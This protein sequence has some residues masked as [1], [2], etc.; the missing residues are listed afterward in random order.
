MWGGIVAFIFVNPLIMCQQ[1]QRVNVEN[2][3]HMNAM[4]KS[5]FV[6]LCS[7]ATLLCHAL[8][9]IRARDVLALLAGYYFTSFELFDAG[10]LIARRRFRT[11]LLVHHTVHA[12]L[13]LYAI[14]R[15]ETTRATGDQEAA[16]SC[17]VSASVLMTQEVSSIWLNQH[18]ANK[19][20]MNSLFLFARLFLLWRVI[21]LGFY[22]FF[23]LGASDDPP[24]AAGVIASWCM[25]L[26]W[27]SHPKM[28]ALRNGETV[29]IN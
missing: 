13:G 10:Q 29:K 20:D 5:I 14:H 19:H 15:F 21:G 1:Q 7:H 16:T 12:L 6:A 17:C 28:R 27:A 11:D 4:I 3:F 25:Q 23:F 18:L 24:M 26:M 2:A 22:I 8:R 9:F